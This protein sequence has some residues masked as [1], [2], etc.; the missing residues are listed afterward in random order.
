MAENAEP[1]TLG[2]PRVDVDL[3]DVEFLCSLKLSVTKIAVIL[4]VSRS[5]LYRRMVED[6]RVLGGYSIIS[7][8]EL[9][10]IVRRIKVSHPNDGEVLMGGHLTRIGIWITRARLRASI[11]RV[12][13]LGVAIRSCCVINRRVYSVPHSNYVWHI[14]SHH[15]LIRWR[16]V[17][18][19]A[20]DGYS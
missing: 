5:T 8:S 16:M 17:I 14:D 12:D 19:G 9:D 10:S 4:G 13:S 18:H 1:G 11:H 20:I 6:R 15:K 3:D 7:D 2:R